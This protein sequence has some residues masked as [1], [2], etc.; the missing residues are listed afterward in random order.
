MS[1]SQFGP[2]ARSLH[3]EPCACSGVSSAC[4][5]IWGWAKCHYIGG[6]TVFFTKIIFLSKL[7]AIVDHVQQSRYNFETA[8]STS[9]GVSAS[10]FSQEVQACVH[11]HA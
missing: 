9:R 6:A 8:S 7:R 5:D 3:F 11:G 2:V 4:K 10:L 1:T